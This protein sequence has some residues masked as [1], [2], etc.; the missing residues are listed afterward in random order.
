MLGIEHGALWVLVSDKHFVTELYQQLQKT[1]G[2]GFGVLASGLRK[3]IWPVA[4]YEDGL[5]LCPSVSIGARTL[6]KGYSTEH[7]PFLPMFS[8]IDFS[9]DFESSRHTLRH[10]SSH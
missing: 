2:F 10:E 3:D 8:V 5:E 1:F 4:S 6:G 7:K 9:Y